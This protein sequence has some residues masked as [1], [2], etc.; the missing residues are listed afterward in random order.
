MKSKLVQGVYGKVRVVDGWRVHSRLYVKRTS[1]K[2]YV[3]STSESLSFDSMVS[4]G[5]EYHFDTLKQL[6]S[7]LSR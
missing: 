2:T 6:H 4:I 5:G 1:V 3:V 7:A